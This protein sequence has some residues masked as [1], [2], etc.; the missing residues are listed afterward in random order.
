MSPRDELVHALG[1]QTT[2]L[3]EQLVTEEARDA[4]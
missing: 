4:S 1:P 2:S 3:I